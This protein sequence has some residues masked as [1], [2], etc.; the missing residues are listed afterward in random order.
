MNRSRAFRLRGLAIALSGLIVLMPVTSAQALGPSGNG[1]VKTLVVAA[2]SG[3][4][5]VGVTV[6]LVYMENAETIAEMVTSKKG[7]GQVGELPLGLYQVSVVR[8]DGFAGAAGPLVH[9]DAENPSA[10]VRFVLE[11]QRPPHAVGP[12]QLPP[13]LLVALLGVAAASA[14]AVLEQLAEDDTP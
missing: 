9:L 13:G 14:L 7:T 6:T 3:E 11:P 5:L 1:A 4:P 12:P 10:T 2:D 8:P